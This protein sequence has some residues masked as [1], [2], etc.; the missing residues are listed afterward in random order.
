MRADEHRQHLPTGPENLHSAK[1]AVR[2]RQKFVRHQHDDRPFLVFKQI[3]QYRSL[4]GLAYAYVDEV[5]VA[6]QISRDAVGRSLVVGNVSKGDGQHGAQD[7]NY[8][9]FEVVE[10]PHP[11]PPLP[12]GANMSNSG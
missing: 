5:H 12:E 1:H 2:V 4:V 3:S 7:R 6:G 8:G 9:W 10:A 11:T